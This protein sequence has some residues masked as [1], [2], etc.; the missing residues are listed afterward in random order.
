MPKIE[1]AEIIDQ[2]SFDNFGLDNSH[3]IKVQSYGGW[4][5]GEVDISCNCGLLELTVFPISNGEELHRHF[6][7]DIREFVKEYGI[8]A[9][10]GET[11]VYGDAEDII[12]A[13]LHHSDQKYVDIAHP[14]FAKDKA[15]VSRDSGKF[16]NSSGN[17]VIDD[18]ADLELS[19]DATANLP[20][21]YS[22]EK[23][24]SD[25]AAIMNEVLSNFH[26][27]DTQDA[28]AVNRFASS[29]A[30]ES[31]RAAAAV[32]RAKIYEEI[33]PDMS[34]VDFDEELFDMWKDLLKF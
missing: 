13:I 8:G 32:T 21:P 20:I 10:L 16:K 15:I 23:D 29:L 1:V 28:A 17:V 11:D 3:V 12:A 2:L 18:Y 5:N 34:N 26:K 7:E 25:K 9:T 27:V 33:D 6:N 31:E 4:G 22:P 30:I 19:S 14:A 24:V